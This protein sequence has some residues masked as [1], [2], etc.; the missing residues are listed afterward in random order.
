M[1]VGLMIL[2]AQKCATTTLFDILD[3]SH[4]I[5]GARVK[6]PHFFSRS[7]DWRRDLPAYHALFNERPGAIYC[8]ASTSYTF[9][10]HRN[11][12]IWDDI[13]AYNPDMKFIYIVRNPVERIIS[14]YVHSVS[15]GYT[16]ASIE[17]F[18]TDHPLTIDVCRYYTQ[19]TP[20]IRRFGKEKVLILEFEELVSHRAKALIKVAAFLAVDASALLEV[21]SVHSNAANTERRHYRF[22]NP[23]FL[24]RIVRKLTP[25]VWQAVVR[26]FTPVHPA[27]PE[28]PRPYRQLV[29]NVLDLEISAMEEL[30][31]RDLSGWRRL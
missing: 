27:K 29:V 2:G 15:R 22:D 25:R 28:L 20:F 30:M 23:P 1:K 6:E 5:A 7:A 14:H 24:L 11:L 13:H 8:E 9:Y 16:R 31:D 3:Q 26:Q 18:I 12:N 19:I 21:G 10:P 4:L 17:Q